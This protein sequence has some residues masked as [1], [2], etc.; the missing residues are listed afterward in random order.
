MRGL[1][2]PTVERKNHHARAMGRD[3]FA[4]AA[5]E[6]RRRNGRRRWPPNPARSRPGRC[7]GPLQTL[8]QRQGILLESAVASLPAPRVATRDLLSAADALPNP[9][10]DQR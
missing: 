10:K 9:G 7:L 3:P 2:V 1:R 6:P 5:F 8:L 4:R